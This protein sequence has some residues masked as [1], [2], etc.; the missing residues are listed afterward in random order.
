MAAGNLGTER[1]EIH[2]DYSLAVILNA[3]N[4]IIELTGQS[5]GRLTVS[6]QDGTRKNRGVVW[7]CNCS[8][9][10]TT[11][12][13]SGNLRFGHVRSCGCLAS[14]QSAARLLTHGHSRRGQLSPEYYSWMG[15][16]TRSSNSSIREWA[17]YGGRGIKVCNRWLNS[18]E[19]F[20]ADMG[21]RPEPK[22]L[23]TVDRINNDGNYEPGN[24][25]W[26]TR[27]EQVANRRPRK[28][29]A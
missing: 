28:R 17:D 23:Y 19:N 21:P 12:A 10:N 20:L 14:E 29:A 16:I 26:A 4:K 18:F 25:R 2:F 8:C 1:V 11:R 5:F 15:I 6:H 9:G 24:C 22:H 7:V 27:K 13:S 3:M